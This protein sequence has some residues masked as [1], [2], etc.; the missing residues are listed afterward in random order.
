MNPSSSVGKTC[1]GEIVIEISSDKAEEHGDWNY[2]EFQDTTNSGG[3]KKTNAMVFYKMDTEEISDRFVASLKL[4]LDLEV[5]RGNKVVK[6]ELI[7][8]LRGEI[9]FVK[10]ILNP[11]ED[12]IEPGVVFERDIPDIEGVDEEAEREALAISMCERYSLLEEERP[13]IKT[14]AY[15]DKYKK[16]LDGICLDKMKQNGMNKEEEED[17]IKIN[18]EALLEKDDHGAFVIPIRLEG[19]VNLNALADT[20]SDV[21]TVPYHIYKEL[22]REDVQNVKKGITML[23]HSKVEPMGLLRDVLCQVGVTTI[24]AKFLILDMPIDR[25]TPIL[26]GR[27]FLHTCSGILNTIE[28]ITSTFDGICHQT[29]RAAQT[30]LDTAE[31]NN[32]DEEEYAIQRNKFGASLYRPK[33]ARR[34]VMTMGGNYD[35]AESSRPKCSRQYEIIED[36]S[37]PQV[38]HEFLLWEGCNRDAKSRNIH[39]YGVVKAFNINEPIYSELCHEFYSTYEFDKVYG[40]DEL[41]T[42]KIIKFRLG[43]RAHSLTLLEFAQRLG[44]YDVEELDE[45][46]FDVYF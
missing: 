3:K 17:M 5:K 36:V 9:Y 15:S 25:D 32:D 18:R 28:R 22:G 33:P 19:K 24:I 14:M 39:F 13:V 7:I 16:T 43:G 26:V 37:L 10:F 40:D 23:N 35:E 2:P 21:N 12:D 6:K 4:C 8:P 27:G 1:L 34:I 20:G 31:S 46:S 41:K 38:H 29:F 45:K 11:E 30:S 42:K 44:L